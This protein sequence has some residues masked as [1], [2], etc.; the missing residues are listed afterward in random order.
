[1]SSITYLFNKTAKK[2]L[3][4]NQKGTFPD[5]WR[6]E[7]YKIYP[8]FPQVILP[9]PKVLKT[10]I[11]SV[12]SKRRSV[13]KFSGDGI[14]ALSI[15]TLLFYSAGINKLPNKEV[16]FPRRAYPS[17]GAR[18]PLEVYLTFFHTTPSIAQGTYHYNVQN[19]RLELL[20]LKLNAQILRQNVLQG[21]NGEMLS[22][23]AGLLYVSSVFQRSNMEMPLFAIV[24]WRLDI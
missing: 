12:F 24:V 1:M 10:P 2:Q 6:K 20:P 18:Y 7:Y 22:T 19:H 5:V 23:A 14:D 9:E 8:R 13:R 17:A 11:G 21:A 16:P 4:K 3:P 15:S